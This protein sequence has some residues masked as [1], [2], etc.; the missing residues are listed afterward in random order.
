MRVLTTIIL[1]LSIT[2]FTGCKDS[3]SG[4]KNEN[5]LNG[6][7][8]RVVNTG[9]VDL[10][11]SMD[12]DADTDFCYEE[13]GCEDTGGH[14][15]YLIYPDNESVVS[16]STPDGQAVGIQ[17]GFHVDAGSGYFE[18]VTGNAYRDDA[19]FLEFD[20]DKVMYTS[21]EFTEGEIVIDTYGEVE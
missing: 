2:L 20:S 5:N 8:I 4:N 18:V 14:G 16:H 12:S 6:L 21:D 10:E 11:L 19:D 7:G 3:S 17:I 15:F 9:D 13:T 1:F